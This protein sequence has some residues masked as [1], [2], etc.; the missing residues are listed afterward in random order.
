ML[1]T[2]PATAILFELLLGATVFYLDLHLGMH[3][4]V[5][6]DDELLWFTS[7]RALMDLGGFT[8][9]G[10]HMEVSWDVDFSNIIEIPWKMNTEAADT[11]EN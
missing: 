9:P 8:A 3:W 6:A 11:F 5:S 2:P 7:L 4:P 1:Q 10:L